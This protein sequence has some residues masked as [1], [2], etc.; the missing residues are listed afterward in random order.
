MAVI[1]SGLLL[2]ACGMSSA[3]TSATSAVAVASPSS[4]A[5]RLHATPSVVAPVGP[6]TGIPAGAPVDPAFSSFAVVSRAVMARGGTPTAA[7][8]SFVHLQGYSGLVDLRTTDDRT[9]SSFEPSWW[10]YLYL[11]VVYTTAPTVEQAQSFLC[12]VLD[13][14]NQPVYVHDNFGNER[15]GVFVALY[16]YSAE[17]WPMRDALAEAD[18]YGAGIDAAQRQFLTEWATAH[19]PGVVP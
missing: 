1:L 7:G 19:P 2:A 10:R 15:T 16:R 14:A 18:L 8:F 6:G 17:G 12:F 11:P 5:G 3:S 9:Y 13:P 4:C